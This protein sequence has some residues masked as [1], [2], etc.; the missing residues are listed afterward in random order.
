MDITWLILRDINMKFLL[1]ITLALA[2]IAQFTSTICHGSAMSPEENTTPKRATNKPIC[3]A[4]FTMPRDIFYLVCNSLDPFSLY[5]AMRVATPWKDAIS[6]MPRLVLPADAAQREMVLATHPFPEVFHRAMNTRNGLECVLRY[7]GFY[8]SHLRSVPC[9]RPA[10]PDNYYARS[11]RA[12]I[13]AELLGE[14]NYPNQQQLWAMD[15]AARNQVAQRLCG[16]IPAL[17]VLAVIAPERFQTHGIQVSNCLTLFRYQEHEVYGTMTNAALY[18]RALTEESKAF[19][20]LIPL[21]YARGTAFLT[22]QAACYRI[23]KDREDVSFETKL[24]LCNRILNSIQY[25]ELDHKNALAK[26]IRA[27]MLSTLTVLDGQTQDLAAKQ[28]I[29]GILEEHFDDSEKLVALADHGASLGIYTVDSVN[30]LYARG[31]PQALDGARVLT[32]QYLDRDRAVGSFSISP[33]WVKILFKSGNRR[34]RELAC[35]FINDY[36]QLD[37]LQSRNISWVR[38]S[39]VFK[40]LRAQD[41]ERAKEVLE[42]FIEMVDAPDTNGLLFAAYQFQNLFEDQARTVEILDKIASQPDHLKPR[43]WLTLSLRYLRCQNNAKARHCFMQVDHKADKLESNELS[44]L[45]FVNAKLGHMQRARNFFQAALEKDVKQAQE[46]LASAEEI[47]TEDIKAIL[48]ECFAFKILKQ[49]SCSFNGDIK[50]LAPVAQP[51]FDIVRTSGVQSFIHTLFMHHFANK[52]GLK[53]EA[54]YWQQQ[55]TEKQNR[56]SVDAVLQEDAV[57]LGLEP[58]KINTL[59]LDQ[60]LQ[61][62]DAKLTKNNQKRDHK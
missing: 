37:N 6:S 50:F 2:L 51:V 49:A 17:K 14:G 10:A 23:L 46:K 26:R 1:R 19:E 47:S 52:L 28:K 21:E 48:D 60:L 36:Y 42:R 18:V 8:P 58:R 32:R 40:A 13:P 30:S 33:D 15:E 54:T 3:I 25:Q 38:S 45:A 53:E 27:F 57:Y 12:T 34:D 43:D 35:D 61:A 7:P 39:C 16:L 20:D 29:A 59:S 22:A 24:V 9:L 11:L 55:I 41:P 44:K 5:R 31:R 56:L 4:N 62:L